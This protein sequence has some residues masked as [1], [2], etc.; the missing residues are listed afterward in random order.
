MTDEARSRAWATRLAPMPDPPA[1]LPTSL[2][3]VYA[4][5]ADGV[6][7]PDRP[8]PE[9]RAAVEHRITAYC[10][11]IENRPLATQCRRELMDLHFRAGRD[12]AT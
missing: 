9:Q 8:T 1:I 3:A 11:A 12:R 4:A 5:L 2:S 10:L 7:D 6:L